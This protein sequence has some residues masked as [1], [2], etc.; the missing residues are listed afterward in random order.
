MT[1]VGGPGDAGRFPDD[2]GDLRDGARQTTGR[3][4]GPSEGAAGRRRALA[5]LAVGLVL[6]MA[7]WFS[8]AAVIPAL[9]EV[10]QL[11]GGQAAWLT[12]AVQLG[13]VGGALVSA[14][15]NL[16]DLVPPRHLIVAGA[17]G[18][19]LANG[20]LLTA[21]GPGWAIPL[22]FLVGFCLAYI[23]PTALKLISTWFVRGR[24]MALGVLV[25]AMTVGTAAPHLVNALGG[26]DW[27]VVIVV[28]S[29][30]TFAGGVLVWS[31][32]REGP[33][34]FPRAVFDIHQAGH[35]LRNRGVRLASLGYFGHMWELFAMWAWFLAF[36]SDELRVVGKESGTTA[37]LATFAVIAI[38]G[39]GCWAGGVL[40]DR[41]GRTQTTILMMSASGVCAV[42]IGLLYG[43]S[44]WLVLG[45]GL[46]WGI[47]VVGDSAQFSA[48][49]T[50]VGEPAYVGTALTLQ[51]A[52]GFVLTVVT[53]RLV[54]ILEA[55]L[56]WHWTF[57]FLAPGP[58]LGVLAMARLH[59]LPE[60]RRIA[61]GR[62]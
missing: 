56:G 44:P 46:V 58:V 23:Y 1:P 6:C 37:A 40:G 22:R 3:A 35:V 54:P 34:A 47:T 14:T 28:T 50:E 2:A 10:W 12:I 42:L 55:S 30:S 53:I 11:S 36:F 5:L 62:G 13:F 18:A 8:A 24:G 51:L 48:M 33:Y 57:A 43:R 27:R 49:V 25:G 59:S 4:D 21:G 16:P 52:V 31:T 45:L 32:V 39:V 61:G 17:A 38:G 29:L 19:A 20:L 41:W 7:P 26:L 15:F 9:R 60:A